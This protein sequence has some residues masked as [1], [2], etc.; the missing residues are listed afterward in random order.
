MIAVIIPGIMGTELTYKG[1]VIWPGPVSDLLFP[2]RYMKELMQ[3][4]LVPTRLIGSVSLSAQYDSLIE[5][6]RICKFRE[7]SQPPTLYT[8]PYDWRLDNR[9]T[10][11][12]L[13][14]LLDAIVAVHG[15]VA[16]IALVAHSMGGLIARYFLE[17]GLFQDRSGYK[18]VRMLITLGT[19]HRGSP[20]ALTAILGFERRLWLNEQQVS[21]LVNN[22]SYP[23]TYQLLPPPGESFAWNRDPAARCS[24]IE[25]YDAAVARNLGL[26]QANLKAAQEF[27]AKLDYRQR[28]VGTR[29]FTFVGTRQTMASHLFMRMPAQSRFVEKF[30]TEDAGDGTVPLWSAGLTGI[31]GQVVGGEHGTIY[32]N[33]ELRRTL[34]IL[35]GGADLLRAAESDLQKKVEVAIRER[36]C[37]P[38]DTVHIALTFTTGTTK[39]KGVLQIE[40]AIMSPS[41]KVIKFQTKQKHAITYAGLSAEKLNVVITSPR[42][43]GVYR[44]A[45]YHARMKRPAGTDE[46]F[47][48]SAH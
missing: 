42:D 7:E 29:Y 3:P 10:A 31:Q 22:P 32:R 44:V 28:P 18:S 35:L 1:K 30:E 14:E 27:H 38:T 26:V 15:E 40:R 25:I 41:G 11:I 34:G 20:E 36:V 43:P 24:P 33:S 45:Y 39:L 19:P 12:K 17:S 23:S 2:Y 6:L 21:E 5:D 48:Q 4:N 46:L 9:T 47:V 13:A 16:E 8:L 37:N